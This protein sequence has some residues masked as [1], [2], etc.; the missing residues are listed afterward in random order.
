MLL[1][2]GS[3]APLLAVL[4]AGTSSHTGPDP[5]H[6]PSQVAGFRLAAELGCGGCHAGLPDPGPA[7]SR[8][9]RFGPEGTPLP[10]DFVYG[11][12]ADPQPR[13]EDIGPTRMPDFSLD[14]RERLALAL[15]LGAPGGGSGIDAARARHPDVD[16]D[17]GRRIFDRLGCAACHQGIAEIV[18]PPGPDL[19]REGTRVRTEWLRAFLSRPGPVRRPGHPGSPGARMPDFRLTVDEVDALARLLEGLGERFANLGDLSLSPFQ[20]ERTRTQLES[21]LACLGCHRVGSDGGRIGPSLN[22]L[23]A[24]VQPDF[25]L[26]MILDPARAAPGSS[27]PHQPMPE[28]DARRITRYLLDLASPRED[29]DLLSLADPDHPAWIASPEGADG[30]APGLYARHCAACHGASG[31]GDGWN[32]EWLPVGPTRHADAASMS[33]R[34]DDTLYDGI[35][36]GAWVLDGS[37]R[38]PPFGGL[39]TPPQIRALVAYIRTLCSCE[40]PPWSRD[41]VRIRR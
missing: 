9:P 13:R 16:G 26:E 17:M 32:A 40:A 22:G 2:K 1:L 4:F 3:W 30:S 24:R 39:L 38:M 25:V 27:M 41:G 10:A 36:A 28:R 33:R 12:L 23:S 34:P 29:P 19:S 6:A 14:E 8:A 37:P 35:Y 18:S 15:F 20:A 7:R 5:T 31:E 21:R 11:Y